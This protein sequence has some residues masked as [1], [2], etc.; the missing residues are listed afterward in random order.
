MII[1]RNLKCL[2]CG[3]ITTT[4]TAIGHADY[5]EIAFPCPGCGVEMRYG[6]KLLLRQRMERVL[7]KACGP[8]LRQRMQSLATKDNIKYVNLKN[9]KG[10]K[11]NG[12][13]TEVLSF[14]GESLIPITGDHFSPFMATARLPIDV[15]QFLGHQNA[16][17]LAVE[18]F[19]P[20]ISRL[21]THLEWRQWSLF[22]KQ[23]HAL[24]LELP[25]KDEADRVKAVFKAVE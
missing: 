7:K 19:W 10:C 13:A 16:R 3:R 1:R 4:R 9:A 11:E 23:F 21:S 12:E 6:M 17:N 24:N 18:K 14:D 20:E 8:P 15:Y 22:D 5:Q 25:I 2:T